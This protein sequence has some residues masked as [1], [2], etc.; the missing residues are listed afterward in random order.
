MCGIVPADLDDVF[1]YGKDQQ[2]GPMAGWR[3]YLTKMDALNALEYFVESNYDFAIYHKKDKKVIGSV[4]L[5]PDKTRNYK[6]ARTIGYCLSSKYRGNGIMTEAFQEFV[7]Y[8][9]TK[10]NIHII[11]ASH[12]P[13]NDKSKRVIEKLGFIYEGMSVDSYQLYNGKVYD[14]LNYYLKR[15]D[16]LKL[17]QKNITK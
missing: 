13:H 17:Y 11:S 6:E 5:Y 9:F 2:V 7:K 12:F 8:L 15:E 14:K 1:E 10:T 4:S 3:P 16:F